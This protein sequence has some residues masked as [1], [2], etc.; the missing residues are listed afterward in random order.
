MFNPS[1]WQR[2]KGLITPPVGEAL[3]KLALSYSD[4]EEGNCF[5]S[6]SLSGQDELHVKDRVGVLC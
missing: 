1:D 2:S 4:D 3:K 6:Q 5:T